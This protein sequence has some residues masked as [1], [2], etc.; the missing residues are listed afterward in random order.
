MNTLLKPLS[1]SPI[2]PSPLNPSHNRLGLIANVYRINVGILEQ[3]A[4]TPTCSLNMS[5]SSKQKSLSILLSLSFALT[6]SLSLALALSFALSL[7]RSHFL[8]LSLSLALALALALA[9]TFCSVQVF[10]DFNVFSV[11]PFCPSRD[12]MFWAKPTQQ[13]PLWTT[14]GM[15]A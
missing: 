11:S 2:D 1:A 3:D 5:I 6:L 9:L 10:I 12:W 7:F 8:S 15:A 4:L 14:P 13:R